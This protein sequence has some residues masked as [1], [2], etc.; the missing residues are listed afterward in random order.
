MRKL[1]LIGMLVGAIMALTV[2]SALAAEEQITEANPLGVHIA[3]EQIAVV[4]PPGIDNLGVGVS[5]NN[6][7]I[8]F[9]RDRIVCEQGFCDPAPV[10]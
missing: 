8:N 2:S 1:L 3:A 7:V 5:G 9:L 10:P 6:F 4:E